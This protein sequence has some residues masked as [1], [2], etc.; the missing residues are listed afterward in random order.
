LAENKVGAWMEM[1]LWLPRQGRSYA[2][3]DR[4]RAAGLTF[5]PI[6]DTIRD[7]LAWAKANPRPFARTGLK[8]ER[9]AELLAKLKG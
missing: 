2:N 5:R 9:E 6:A 8:P 3:N 7:T 4:A 1:P